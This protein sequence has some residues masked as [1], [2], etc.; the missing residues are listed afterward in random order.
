[1]S[2]AHVR[3]E[4]PRGTHTFKNQII[5]SSHPPLAIIVAKFSRG[6]GNLVVSTLSLGIRFPS[7]YPHSVLEPL[8]RTIASPSERNAT[9][10]QGSERPPP[11]ACNLPPCACTLTHAFANSPIRTQRISLKHGCWIVAQRRVSC[12]WPTPQRKAEKIPA[13]RAQE[14]T[15]FWSRHRNWRFVRSG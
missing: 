4:T 3:I 10:K 5:A 7:E 13:A 9:A 1:M 14:M 6:P 15:A 11:T 2:A 8:G 12:R